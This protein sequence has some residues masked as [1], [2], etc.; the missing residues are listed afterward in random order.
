MC[1]CARSRFKGTAA[2]VSISCMRCGTVM[3]LVTRSA[4][5]STKPRGLQSQRRGVRFKRSL[6]EEAQ[7]VVELLMGEATVT[8]MHVPN[9]T[10]DR[11]QARTDGRRNRHS[12]RSRSTIT[13]CPLRHRRHISNAHQSHLEAFRDSSSAFFLGASSC[14]HDQRAEIRAEPAMI[15]PSGPEI[16]AYVRHRSRT[17]IC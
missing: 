14:T 1:A 13:A 5:F 4:P 2:P 16:H 12:H 11:T 9:H 17:C 8:I 3:H 10:P 15:S 6:E 7:G